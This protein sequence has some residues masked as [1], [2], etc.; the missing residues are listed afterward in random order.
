MFASFYLFHKDHEK[1]TMFE[2]S[3]LKSKHFVFPLERKNKPDE[4]IWYSG[5]DLLL[6]KIRWD[7]LKT[8]YVLADISG[9]FKYSKWFIFILDILIYNIYRG[10][11]EIFPPSTV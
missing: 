2:I 9:D 7:L 8:T 6:T 11:A 1:W 3:D 4:H 10:A 5:E